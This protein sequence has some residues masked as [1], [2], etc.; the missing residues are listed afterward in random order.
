[1]RAFALSLVVVSLVTGCFGDDPE[2]NERAFTASNGVVTAGWAYG[3]G[4]EIGGSAEINGSTIDDAN[5]GAIHIEFLL[6]D[7][8]WV[9]HFDAF[10]QA[11]GRDFQDGGIEHGLDEHGDTG[12]ADASIPRIHANVAAWGTASVTRNGALVTPEPWPAHL[13][14]SRD[15]VRNGGKITKADGTTPYDPG[16][17][18]DALTV[19]NDPQ[20]LFFVKHPMGETFMR[21]P[22][23]TF[24]NLTCSGPQCSAPGEVLVEDGATKLVVNATGRPD[25]QLP[26]AVGRGVSVLLS[27]ANGVQLGMINLG[28]IVAGPVPPPTGNTE[29]VLGPDFAGPVTATVSGDGAFS[30][31]I[32]AT[33]FY[34]DHP[35]IVIVWD[36]PTVV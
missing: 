8:P 9:I 29:I 7:Q 12:V 1:M 34:D 11:E 15:S 21:A 27:D 19:E 3:G 31:A 30:V 16:T 23:T 20:V 2:P 26:L 36:E 33:A 4:G 17:P 6:D 24:L 35:F 10:A 5:T 13:M 28:D 25:G 32:D 22:A 18:A 14:V